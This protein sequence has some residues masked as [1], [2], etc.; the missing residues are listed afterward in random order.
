MDIMRANAPV[1]PYLAALREL[2]FVQEVRFSEEHGKPDVG[3]DGTLTLR[4]PQKTHIFFVHQKRSYLDRSLLNAAI[5]QAKAYRNPIFLFARYVPTPSA[6][7]L[8]EAGINFID[9]TGN[10]H[11][12]LG[13]NY[14]RTIIGK[15][16]KRRSEQT[17]RLTPATV[18]LLFAFAAH[19]DAGKW[20]VRQLADVSGL[21]KSNAA[22]LRQQLID[23]GTL[24]NTEKNIEIT[25][26]QKLEDELLQGYELALRPKLYLGRF[27]APE[28]KADKL[29]TKTR[30]AFTEF[31]V[32]WSLTGGAGAY[33]LQHFYRGLE[34]ALFAESFSDSL[35]RRM[36]LI[37]DKTGPLIF[38]RAFGA[39]PFWRDL[40]GNN[41]AHPWLIYAELMNSDDARAHE[42]A[43]EIKRQYLAP[44]HA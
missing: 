5:A 43:Q 15:K 25:E 27:R 36:R 12:N 10:I 23:Q 34:S 17:H 35:R 9:Q 8:M 40:E 24:R 11:L 31:G 41:I 6:E 2:P 42:A 13:K 4:T 14:E 37:P 26:P 28:S 20:S 33:A 7:R 32:R 39:L 30:E 22:K 1:Q 44:T 38:L 19:K 29:L 21:S 18:Q 16:E 3:I